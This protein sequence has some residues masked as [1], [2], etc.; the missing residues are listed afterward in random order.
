[1]KPAIK[2]AIRVVACIALLP[3]VPVAATLGLIIGFIWFL[4]ALVALVGLAFHVTTLGVDEGW[5]V[6]RREEYPQDIF[7]WMKP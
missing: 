5:R 7:P 1:M 4:A 6:W 3:F 2:T